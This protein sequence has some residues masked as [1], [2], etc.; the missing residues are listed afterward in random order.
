VKSLS[1]LVA[2]VVVANLCGLAS[3]DIGAPRFP[4]PIF[5]QPQPVM[6]QPAPK[7]AEPAPLVIK[8]DDDAK[9]AK[10]QIPYEAIGVVR[11]ALD[12]AEEPTQTAGAGSLPTVASGCALALAVS[13]LGLWLVRSGDSFRK[14]G[15]VLGAVAM[16]VLAAGSATIG[17]D[18]GKKEAVDPSETVVVEITKERGVPVTLT[19]TK[20]RL[21]KAIESTEKSE[22]K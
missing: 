17:A 2:L 1:Y 12:A 16:I 5:P 9:R 15:L 18:K 22:K 14:R 13:F 21:T 4:R 7:A 19:I 10:L 11:A 8:I 6:P 3:A 20:A